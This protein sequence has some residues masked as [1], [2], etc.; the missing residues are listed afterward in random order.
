MCWHRNISCSWNKCS[1]SMWLNNQLCGIRRKETN[2]V[3]TRLL[4][5]GSE[6]DRMDCI[7]KRSLLCFPIQERQWKLFERF[8]KVIVMKILYSQPRSSHLGE[9]QDV[10]KHSSLRRTGMQAPHWNQLW[11]D[12]L[13]HSVKWRQMKNSWIEN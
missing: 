4:I 3:F 12:V 6:E 8:W 5:C 11:E 13:Y 1:P 9:K 10:L 7:A 2:P